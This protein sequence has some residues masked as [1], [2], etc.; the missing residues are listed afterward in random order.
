[1]TLR[2]NP[3]VLVAIEGIDGAG[4]T[5]QAALVAERLR[6]VGLEVVRTKEPT[7]GPWGQRLRASAATGRLSSD[8]ELRAFVEDRREHVATL[9]RPALAAGQVVIVDRYYFSTAAYQGARGM[10]PAELLRLNEAFAPEPD[11]L[12][13]LEVAPAVGVA[14]IRDR[15]GKGGNLF[16]RE[17]DL[18]KS[19]AIF[20]GLEKSYLLRLDG[21]RPR[22]E[23]TAAILAALH[24][25]PLWRR[26][27]A[28]P[29]GDPDGGCPPGG[30]LRA[31]GG[32]DY[33]RL[34]L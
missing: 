20:A 30:C 21:T 9:I 1:V 10:D 4:K 15:E 6:A 14:R 3:G 32:C 29:E 11:L 27:C 8:E 7:D 22:E 34:K 5:T 18:G 33:P 28:A 19:A 12:V 23:L 17:E 16:E 25:G 2:L 26:L 31:A 13:L 24:Q